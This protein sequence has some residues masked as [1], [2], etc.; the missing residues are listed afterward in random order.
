M[1]TE[2]QMQAAMSELAIVPLD[3]YIT[4]REARTLIAWR[5]G[6]EYGLEG[7]QCSEGALRQRVHT[8]ALK[9]HQ[10]ERADGTI[11]PRLHLYDYRDIFRL[12]IAPR[13]GISR[14]RH[15]HAQG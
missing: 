2:N 3:S 7:Y 6:K 5:A 11:H 9:A 8:G 15:T 13:R 14:R 4:S 10:L 1:Y 12:R